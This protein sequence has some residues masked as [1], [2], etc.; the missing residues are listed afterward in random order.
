M[1]YLF[2]LCLF[3]CR[4]L[5]SDCWLYFYRIVVEAKNPVYISCKWLNE[6]AASAL[7]QNKLM[8]FCT[9]LAFFYFPCYLCVRACVRFFFFF[10][11]DSVCV[12]VFMYIRQTYSLD[13]CLKSNK[14][15]CK[16]LQILFIRKW[17]S[18]RLQNF[19]PSQSY[20][21][22]SVNDWLCTSQV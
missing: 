10:T 11:F 15:D 1:F 17:L 13:N 9:G 7:G 2:S 18:F 8:N 12:C 21:H 5:M 22:L 3:I 14:F 4:Q 19:K 16:K 20:I 6:T